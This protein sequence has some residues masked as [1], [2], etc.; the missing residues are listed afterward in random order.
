MKDDTE[1][2]NA[3]KRLSSDLLSLAKDLNSEIWKDKNAQDWY[4][5]GVQDS[6][7][8]LMLKW[9]K[10]DEENSNT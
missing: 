5:S 10:D 9:I 2:D 1:Y 8:L 6:A 7:H 4:I 3:I